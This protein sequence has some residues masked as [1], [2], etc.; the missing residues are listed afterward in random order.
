MSWELS[1]TGKIFNSTDAFNY[2]CLNKVVSHEEVFNNCLKES[3]RL[4]FNTTG[5]YISIKKK[6]SLK[7]LKN[8]NANK[9]SL[10]DEFIN[11][12]FSKSTKK[13]FMKKVTKLNSKI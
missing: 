2:K 6:L 5:A 9:N 4:D 1:L 13:M 12:L 7:M 8:W 3:K 11:V 10:T